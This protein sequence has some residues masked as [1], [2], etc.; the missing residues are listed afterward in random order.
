MGSK[1]IAGHRI[2]LK[3]DILTEFIADFMEQF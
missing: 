1:Q 2:P 3:T